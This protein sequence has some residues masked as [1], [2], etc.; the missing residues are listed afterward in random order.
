MN[1][2]PPSLL[3]IAT[4]EAPHP[5]SQAAIED[6][7]V[8]LFPQGD[9][10][11]SELRTVFAN[12]G[13]ER[14]TLAR[15]LEDYLRP[16]G[17]RE[18]N[19]L[20][21]SCAEA[22]LRTAAERAVPRALASE[23]THIITVSSSGVAT[24]SLECALIEELGL[25]AGAQRI[26]VFGLGCGGGVAALQL[27]ADL[28]R[29]SE[30]ALVLVLCAELTSLTLLNADDSAR[31]FV[32]C[33]LFGDGAAAALVGRP[34]DGAPALAHL[35]EGRTQTFPGTSDLM[36]WDVR[37]DGWQVVFSQRIP[38]VVAREVRPFVERL[39]A[40]R[41]LEHLLLHPGGRRVLDAYRTALELEPGRMVH[42]EAVL[43]RHGNMSA[44]TVF[45]VIERC[46]RDASTRPGPG[47]A[48]AFGP[49]FTANAL[50]LD[51]TGVQ[52]A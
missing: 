19:A 30:D 48:T 1:S 14:R 38:V 16:T 34:R 33:A 21:L 13:I 41:E 2:I 11:H 40:P 35:G 39:I 46:L 22:L 44:A 9:F 15:P 47:I 29:S 42:A 25:D 10:A 36:G 52:P 17:P 37:D 32:A 43:A 8:R 51:P 12:A 24:P 45:F 28:A 50:R 31:N 27:A 18:R 26:P 49:G 23:V 3:S 7:A 20:F 5:V 6:V 4:A